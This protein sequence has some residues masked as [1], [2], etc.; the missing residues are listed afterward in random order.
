MV[1]VS[2]TTAVAFVWHPRGHRPLK[3]NDRAARGVASGVPTVNMSGAANGLR[4]L[5]PPK[6]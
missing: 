1:V 4:T 5:L 2:A 3:A 6:S